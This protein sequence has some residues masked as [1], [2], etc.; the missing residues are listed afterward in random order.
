[1]KNLFARLYLLLLIAIVGLGWG[2]EQLY[3]H[4]GQRQQVTNDL[5]LHRGTLFLLD[6][7]LRRRPEAQRAS[8]VDAIQPSFGFPLQLFQRQPELQLKQLTGLVLSAQQRDYL[9]QG[10]VITWFDDD[11]GHSWFVRQLSGTQHLIVLGPIVTGS[12]GHADLV[13]LILFLAGLGIFVF[14]WAMP[15]SRGLMTLTQTATKFGQGDFS[16]RAKANVSAPLQNLVERFNAMAERIQRLL[17]S[18]KELSHGISHELRTPIARLRFAM[19]MVRELDDPKAVAKYLD[20]MDDNIEQLD[21]L[22][23]ELLTYARFDREEP[24]LQLHLEDMSELADLVLENFRLTEPQLQFQL[25]TETPL[26][27]IH[28]DREAVMRMLDNLI[29]NA[30]RYAATVVEVNLTIRQQQL[31]VAVNDDGPGVPVESRSSLFEPFVRL[32]KSRDRKSGGIGLG[33]AIVKRYVKLHRG[34][35]RI[36]DSP[37]GGASFI[38]SWP[39]QQSE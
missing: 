6:G 2:V 30:V 23:D 1:M 28:C 15:I 38:L 29:R 37:L 22:V 24:L 21:G 32:D 5:D 17:K 9:Q 20:T 11:G 4:Y 39:V 26:P 27:L 18:H 36:D 8:F 13:Y 19:E 34:E 25:T 14:A 7:E 3:Q 33:L 12:A 31:L 16:A 10:G 35:V